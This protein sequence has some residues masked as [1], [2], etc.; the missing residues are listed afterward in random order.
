MATGSDKRQRTAQILVRL[1]TEE[2]G[3]LAAKADRAGYTRAAFAR[4]ALLGDPGLRARRLPPAD[5]VM[6]RRVLA[7]LGRVGNNLNQLARG[8]N[9]GEVPEVPELRD[10]ARALLQ[11]RD[12]IFE[13]LG[14][15]PA[16]DYQ[17]KEPG[18]P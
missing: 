3:I 5:H 13:A 2:L 10:A 7:D 6:L 12:A 17:R 4:A 8:M 1:T 15:E 18:W 16:G 14:K 9:M 11:A